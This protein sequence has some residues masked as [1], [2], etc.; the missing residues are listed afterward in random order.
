MHFHNYLRPCYI[1]AHFGGCLLHRSAK[2]LYG[3]LILIQKYD[4]PLFQVH[5][6]QHAR[7]CRPIPICLSG[8]ELTFALAKKQGFRIQNSSLNRQG[9]GL[10]ADAPV[11]EQLV[12]FWI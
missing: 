1:D 7:S 6:R 3:G 11:P 8:Y 2:G 12:R 10:E 4:G 5:W 9:I